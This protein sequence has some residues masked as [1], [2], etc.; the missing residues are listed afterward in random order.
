VI[1][2]LE[3]K[4]VRMHAFNPNYLINIANL[5]ILAAFAVR[6][7][8]LLRTFFLAGSA[9]AIG[10]YYFQSPPLWTAIAWTVLYCVIHAYWIVRIMM[11]RRPVVLTPDEETLYRL[12]FRSIGKRKFARLAGLGRWRDAEKDQELSKEGERVNE[13]LALISGKIAA[14]IRDQ[15]VGI[16]GPGELVGTAGVLLNNTQQC[17]FVV[18][19]PARYIAWPLAEVQQ[20]LNKDPDLRAQI[21]DITSEELAKKIHNMTHPDAK[22]QNAQDQPP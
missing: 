7:V 3:E 14:R 15:T 21:R 8:L 16:L 6:D 5:L 20:F 17:D 11:E 19:T 10:Y 1:Q 9:F 4:S 18:E 12:A 22:L 13:I 2:R